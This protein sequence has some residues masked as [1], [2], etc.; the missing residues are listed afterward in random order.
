M[1]KTIIYYQNGKRV[2]EKDFIPL[3]KK[4]FIVET[5]YIAGREINIF[6]AQ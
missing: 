1:K 5:W 2:S 3:F 4:Y 6:R